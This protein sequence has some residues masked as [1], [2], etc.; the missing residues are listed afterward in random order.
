M[1]L[2]RSSTGTRD[3]LDA[4]AARHQR[5]FVTGG[6]GYIGNAFIRGAVSDG[7]SVHAL[8]RSRG[9][10]ARL[11]ELGAA[12]VAGDLRDPTGEWTSIARQADVVVHLAQPQTFGG[13]VTL[14]R[15]RRYR[16]QRLA[17]D[18]ALFR[19]LDPARVQRIVYVAGTS[20]YGDIGGVLC[21]EDV[22]PNPRGWGPYMAPAIEALDDQI[23]RGLPIVSAFPGWVYGPASWFAQYVLEPLHAGRPVTGLSGPS[24]HTSPIH[25]DDCARALIHLMRAG[26]VGKRY[27]VVDDNPIPSERLA[28]FAAKALNVTPRVRKLPK[29]L[30]RVVAGQVIADSLSYDSRLSNARLRATGFEPNFPSSTEGVP[31]VVAAWRRDL[32]SASN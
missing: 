7:A 12:P 4:G 2:T 28:E 6:S 8:A 23:A 16:D 11:Q 5:V 9:T 27:F 25:L 20:Y 24:R 26:E 30:F 21:N 31:H 10:V 32:A 22:T 13:R 15:A 1:N 14:V 3:E 29:L 18:R 17:M 19:A